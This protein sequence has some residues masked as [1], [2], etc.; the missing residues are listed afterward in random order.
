MSGITIKNFSDY[1]TVPLT[2]VANTAA[3]VSFALPGSWE[4]PDVQIYNAGSTVAFVNFCYSGKIVNAQVPGTNGTTGAT[5]VP[6]GAIMVFSKNKGATYNDTCCAISTG[7]P[8]LY[9]TS[10]VG[11]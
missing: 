5:P 8:T 1:E 9:F 4:S 10:G 6:A 3:T 2:L 11:S 7:T